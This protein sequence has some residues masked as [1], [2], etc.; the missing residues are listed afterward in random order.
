MSHLR[1]NNFIKRQRR[2]VFDGLALSGSWDCKKRR[3]AV[4]SVLIRVDVDRRAPAFSIC[5]L[6]VVGLVFLGAARRFRKAKEHMMLTKL[7]NRKIYKSQ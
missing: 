3:A 1:S 4:H 6:Y 7:A 5:S 2:A